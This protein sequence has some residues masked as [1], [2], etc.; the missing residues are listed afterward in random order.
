MSTA[1]RIA[2]IDPQIA[3][4]SGDM[5]LAAIL[6]LLP[7]SQRVVEAM[8]VV[9]KHH[10]GCRRIELRVNDV[11][12]RGFKAKRAEVIADESRN[13]MTGT[14]LAETVVKCADC[15]GLSNEARLFASKSISSLVQAE[16]RVHG[17]SVEQAHLHEASSVDTTA[18]I[19]GTAVA[20]EELGLFGDTLIYSM[21]VAVGGGLFSFS[22]GTVQSPAPAT[23]EILRSNAFT[24]VGGPVQSELTTPTGASILVNLARESTGSYPA[25]RLAEVGCGAGT[26][27]F[28]EMPNVVRI[29]LGQPVDY[30]LLTDEIYELET[31]LDD[32]SGEIVGHAV[33]RLFR[34]GARDVCVIPMLTKKSRPG[35]ILKVIADREKADWLSRVLIDETGTLGVRMRSCKR[36]TLGR[37]ILSLDM[38]VGDMQERVDVKISTDSAG[39]IVQMKPEYDDLEKLAQKT[40]KTLRELEDLARTRAREV[41]SKR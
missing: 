39:R 4:I 12:R 29:I 17:E 26:K 2:V 25:I 22:H 37:E 20:L 1:K 10:K 9:Q 16:A 35:H 7:S 6:D 32:V 27:D 33:D 11:K 19:I 31:N 13:E 3:G 36:R 5:I 34:E 8:T 23:L 15:L 30:Q 40:G 18:E 21:P 38:S 24:I 28:A 14:E 41:L